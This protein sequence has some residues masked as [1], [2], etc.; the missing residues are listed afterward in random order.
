MK[1]HTLAEKYGGGGH[2]YTCGGVLADKKQI[3]SLIE[4]AD[5]M[6]K[7]YKATHEGWL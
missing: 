2:E 7:E 3:K 4:D 6:V 1:I 5:A